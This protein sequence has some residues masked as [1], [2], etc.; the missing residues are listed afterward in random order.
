M[1]QKSGRSKAFTTLQS[2]HFFSQHSEPF[3]YLGCSL[4][5]GPDASPVN[6][7]L[8]DVILPTLYLK[9]HQLWRSHQSYSPAA[10]K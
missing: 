5:N 3:W 7:V 9:A 6:H 1:L 2:F 8:P 10:M 4:L